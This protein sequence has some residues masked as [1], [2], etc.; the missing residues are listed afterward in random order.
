MD[1]ARKQYRDKEYYVGINVYTKKGA[2]S[3]SQSVGDHE[4]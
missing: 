2:L 1:E 3:M 4:Q